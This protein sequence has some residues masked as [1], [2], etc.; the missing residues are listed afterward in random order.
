MKLSIVLS[1][2]PAAFSALAYKGQLAE[3]VAKIAAQGY[4]GVEIAV[5]DPKLLNTSE[6]IEIT[7]EHG[8]VIPAI[9]T[10]QAFGE[11]G[12]S[13]IHPKAEIREQAIERI[14]SQMDLAIEVNAVVII[15]LIR[16]I[17][18]Q[19]EVG[20]ADAEARCREAL[21]VCA[22]YRPDLRL[23]IEPINRYES[24]QLCTVDDTL[25]FLD[26]LGRDNVG[27][28]LDT[29]HMNIEEPS[30]LESIRRAGGRI[31]HFHIADSNRWYPGAGH[32]DFQE[33]VTVL[34]QTGYTGFL[35]AEIMPLPDPDTAASETVTQMRR[36][37]Q[38]I[39]S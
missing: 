11:E 12:L 3:N 22:D 24:D 28:L 32:L 18:S 27:L 26:D 33:I 13:F 1:T 25:R 23:A 16:G 4:D 2:Q 15:G 10:G 8:M 31:F 38:I 39:E 20:E 36:I 17:R 6:V 29:F 21:Q 35:S 9:G 14:K 30:P 5:R 37:E 34:S 19:V 7:S